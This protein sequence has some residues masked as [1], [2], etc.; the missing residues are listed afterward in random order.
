M[1]SN[2][3]IPYQEA[4]IRNKFLFQDNSEELT[5]CYI[6]GAKTIINQPLS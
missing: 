3:N 4:F 6:F 2:I 5:P 1:T